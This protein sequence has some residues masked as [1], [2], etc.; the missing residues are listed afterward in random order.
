MVDPLMLSRNVKEPRKHNKIT[1]F[2]DET[3]IIQHEGLDIN[4][5]NTGSVM[6]RPEKG[7]PDKQELKYK[8]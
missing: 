7:R 1:V 4:Q 6:S 8:G 2:S 3:G 5:R